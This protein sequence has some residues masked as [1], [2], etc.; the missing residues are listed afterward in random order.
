[1]EQVAAGYERG[2]EQTSKVDAVIRDLFGSPALD[3]VS[4]GAI[5]RQMSQ[6]VVRMRFLLVMLGVVAFSVRPGVGQYFFPDGSD[7]ITVDRDGGPTGTG[8]IYVGDHGL[9]TDPCHYR[10]NLPA[11]ESVHNARIYKTTFK[12]EDSFGVAFVNG[13]GELVTIPQ[14]EFQKVDKDGKP[15][16][17]GSGVLGRAAAEPVLNR[18]EVSNDGDSFD[19]TCD[20]RFAVVVGANSATPVSLVD[21]QSGTEVD[22]LAFEGIGNFVAACDDG[23][24]VLVLLNGNQ[25]GTGSIR[26]VTI[27]AAGRLV[28]TGEVFAVGENQWIVKIFAVPGSKVGVAFTNG[29]MTTFGIPGLNALDSV[30]FSHVDLSAAVAC[31]G[32]RVYVRRSTFIEGYSLDPGTGILGK[33]PFLTITNVAPVYVHHSYGSALAISRDGTTLIASEPEFSPSAGVVKPQVSFFDAATGERKGAAAFEDGLVLP[34]VGSVLP[35]C[36]TPPVRLEVEQLASGQIRILIS[37]SVGQQYEL[38]KSLDLTSWEKLA[39]IEI[40]I[41]PFGYT[42]TEPID[43]NRFYRLRW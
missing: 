11:G 15:C 21:I 23:E 22:K 5:I 43:S 12:G 9:F 19:L 32:D 34:T 1:M 38:Q 42:D 7:F 40:S 28:D 26:R 6:S 16:A 2:A 27:S 39:D 36:D 17:A 37:G 31:T 8:R 3:T 10:I 25:I 18:I 29:G 33:T 4:G 14:H 35:C 41:L 30:S 24:S 13:S 20:G